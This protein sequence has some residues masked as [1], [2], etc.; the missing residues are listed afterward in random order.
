MGIEQ[1]FDR[2]DA[3]QEVVMQYLIQSISMREL[4]CTG[5]KIVR[6]CLVMFA[7]PKL[8]VH[9]MSGIRERQTDVLMDPRQFPQTEGKKALGSCQVRKLV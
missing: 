4:G 8:N 7:S 3:L 5:L 1:V 2:N 6:D 9:G